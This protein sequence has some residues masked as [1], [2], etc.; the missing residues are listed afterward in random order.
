[1]RVLFG[2][3][4]GEDTSQLP[5]RYL[6]WLSD[7]QEKNQVYG[8]PWETNFFKINPALQLAARQELETRGYTKKGLRWER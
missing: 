4:K 5:D 2:R 7:Q 3:H 6:M 8:R 1:M